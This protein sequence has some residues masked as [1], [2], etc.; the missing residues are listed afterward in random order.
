MRLQRLGALNAV[1]QRRG[2]RAPARHGVWAF[3]W[4]FFDMYYAAHKFET[5][6]P[7]A[8]RQDR[9]F[10]DLVTLPEDR[11]PQTSEE[12]SA[13][14]EA[15]ERWVR[16]HRRQVMPIREFWWDAPVYTHLNRAGE[17]VGMGDWELL[18]V[19]ELERAI[20][21]HVAGVGRHRFRARNYEMGVFEVFAPMRR[22]GRDRRR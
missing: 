4:P 14:W 15:R 8:L 3:P 19:V 11:R 16:E 9:G 2:S 7:K 22:G 17:Y 18:G 6:M 13:Y 10:D 20:R 21:R 1:R 12:W 5:A